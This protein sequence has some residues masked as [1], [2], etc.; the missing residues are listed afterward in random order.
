MVDNFSSSRRYRKSIFL[1]FVFSDQNFYRFAIFSRVNES[2]SDFFFPILTARDAIIFRFGNG[3]Y[4][5]YGW[6]IVRWRFKSVTRIV[7]SRK[8]PLR[9]T[10][11]YD[12][13]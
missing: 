11:Y 9:R 8:A 1:R 6:K 12:V 4:Q 13:E 2:L 3:A 10:D 5:F 7:S